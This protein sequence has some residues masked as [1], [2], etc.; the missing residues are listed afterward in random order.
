MPPDEATPTATAPPEGGEATP[1]A[2][3]QNGGT[4][5]PQVAPDSLERVL[6]RMEELGNTVNERFSTIEQRLP[7]PEAEPEPDQTADLLRELGYEIP[8]EEPG[9]EEEGDLNLT[10]R[11]LVE[12][13]GKATNQSVQQQL[14]EQLQPHLAQQRE[15]QVEQAFSDLE[16]RY[17]KLAEDSEWQQKVGDT[18]EALALR[19]AEA[20]E[21]RTQQA[22]QLAEGLL[23]NPHFIELVHKSLLADERAAQ[24]TPV[25][26][27][28]EGVERPSGANPTGGETTE[29]P[30]DAMIQ[31]VGGDKL[32]E[33]GLI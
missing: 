17:P 7:K 23:D 11:D 32:R 13:I 5:S 27:R 18:G 31:A 14:A 20:S 24:E 28:R 16:E 33:A 26:P 15:A 1:T 6:G 25:A 4:G 29:N 22:V 10:P 19:I 2:P 30:T 9:Q 21:G 12:L 8:E 3:E